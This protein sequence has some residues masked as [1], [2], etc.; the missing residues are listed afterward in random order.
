MGI[1][2]EAALYALGYWMHENHPARIEGLCLNDIQK[3]TPC[4]E[5]SAACPAGLS[6]HTKTPDWHGCTDC[7]L[8]VT[9]CP[10]QA[11]NASSACCDSVEHAAESARGCVVL[12]C[13]RFEG[14]A[15]A[16]VPCLAALCWDELAAIALDIPVVLKTSPCKGCPDACAVSRL[17]KTVEQLKGFFG[18][19]E[20]GRRFFPRIPDSLKA[21][22]SEGIAAGVERRRAFASVAGSVKKGATHLANPD[23][24]PRASRSR[25]MLIDALENMPANERPAVRWQTLVEDGNCKGCG[26]CVNMCPHGALAL[27]TEAERNA[28]CVAQ[29]V[30][31]EGGARDRAVPAEGA[32]GGADESDRG[33]SAVAAPAPE[34]PASSGI[35]RYLAHDASRCT[36][37]GLCYMS[38]PQENLGG[39]DELAT[40]AVPAVRFNPI[41][42]ARCEKCG[43]LFKAEPGKTRCPACSRFR[44]APR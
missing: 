37:C 1:A 39:W 19:E 21:E 18:P 26:I 29:D 24:T 14:H 5:C 40:S 34:P 30:E 41:D 15:D 10:S 8:C 23:E 2:D 25:T 13:T 4:D 44:F 7:G 27:A 9:A 31:G 17:K 32:Q 38:C 20:F 16:V 3:K 36:Q 42:V 43:R 12:A 22:H 35:P 33:A 28:H 6:I 11:I